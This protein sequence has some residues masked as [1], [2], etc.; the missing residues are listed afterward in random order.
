[1]NS[2]LRSIVAR[3]SLRRP[4]EQALEVLANV[5]EHLELSK[6][7]DLARDLDTI[8]QQYPAV[9]DF[10]HPFPSL[11]FA[12]ATGVGKT[13]LMGA[14][15]SYLYLTGRSR[16]FFVLA[17][18]LTIYEKLKTDFTAES[19]KYVFRGIQE[20]IA[21]RPVIITG[22][23]YEG[24]EGVRWDENAFRKIGRVFDDRATPFI[25]IF[26]ISK[27]NATEHKKGATKSK[28]P[29]IKR[30]QETLG[31]SYF[32]YLA[33]LPD[34][35][36]LMDEAHRYRANAG[37]NAL[38]ELQPVLGIELTATPKTVGAKSVD[39]KNTIYR[40]PLAE[41]LHDGY[42]KEPAVA[43]R[44]D[45]KPENYPPAEL[46]RIKLEDGIHC[47]EEVKHEI[48]TYAHNHQKKEVK[49]FMLVVA[50]DTEHAGQLREFLESDGFFAGSYRGKVAEVHSK[51]SG[52]EEDENIQRLISVEDSN[53]P[54]EIVIHVNKLKE[55]WDVTN[56][57]TIVPLRA[58]ASEILTEQTI[59]R[60]LRLPYGN[61]TNVAAVDRLT[62]IAHDRFQEII[63][64]ANAPTSLLKK[65]IEIGE[66]GD[67][68][69]EKTETIEVPPMASA[70][71]TGACGAGVPSETAQTPPFRT[72]EQ[73]KV[74]AMTL[75][76]AKRYER[77]NS[78]KALCDRETQTQIIKEV[79]EIMQGGQ[80][81]FA[82]EPES[83]SP[84]GQE[85]KAVLDH[86]A[87]FTIDI[88]N[89]VLIPS[90]AVTYGF[91]DFDLEGLETLN[92]SPVSHKILLYQ[93]RNNQSSWLTRSGEGFHP[94]P[95]L[96]NYLIRGLIEYDPVDYD[97][98]A[99]LLYKLAGQVIDH[100]RGYLLEES[101]VENVLLHHQ[102]TLTDFIVEQLVAHS[103]ET[104]TDYQVHV[105]RG[106]RMLES[107][108]Y[109]CQ[110]TT[111]NFW[112]TPAKKS[113]VK[114]MVFEGFQKCC[115]PFQKFDSVEGELYFA[116]ILE[117]DE[118]VLRWLKPAPGFF[119]IR[120][121]HG[122]SYEP[123]FV[124]E[125]A[126]DKYL[127]EPKRASDMQNPEVLAKQAAAVRWC[128]HAT[129]HA[130]ETHT[131]PWHYALIPHN[132]IAPQKSFAGLM[133]EFM[134]PDEK[135]P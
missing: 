33:G 41:A 35:V 111:R 12:L 26:N 103:W 122:V 95:R 96:E 123:D 5:V 67:V 18:N 48:A 90:D 52:A 57:Y 8:R 102:R 16:H 37:A 85:V 7:P 43:T 98:H 75:A 134:V 83:E 76:V 38:K 21:H 120:G 19:E 46:E 114:N 9:E 126:T 32:D 117:Q 36:L 63:E 74:L 109:N 135:S 15:I 1:M 78:A 129:Q 65:A 88:P 20:W 13:R 28:T 70:V 121:K 10:E 99:D 27:I 79:A 127:C 39:F 69:F 94:E 87:K 107:V 84:L 58:S 4:Q 45:F 132:A 128:K 29:R 91:H 71:L 53:N 44:K 31:E 105:S 14:F 97:E 60:G 66:G 112:E 81:A 73:Q 50:Q 118:S 89:I 22:E 131:K 25:N 24:G 54:T 34:L 106:F 68:S 62:I 104:P 40:Y 72:P 100:F 86:L 77:L 113:H 125:T 119:Q 92:F 6:T 64:R 3:L 115:Y 11:C 116:R 56:L 17:P 124:V 101:K 30:L 51:Q 108:K 55:G 133:Q 23:T 42:V 2:I 82:L 130:Q 80:G 110:E 93:L 49:P 61:R 47:H 59:G